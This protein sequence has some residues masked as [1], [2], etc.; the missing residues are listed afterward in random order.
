[1]L[2]A[3]LAALHAAGRGELE[4]RAIVFTGLILANLVLIF[5]NRSWER[6]L[7]EPGPARN[8]ALWW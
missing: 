1:M 8:G 4:A 6:T 3:A 7:A 5:S 2:I